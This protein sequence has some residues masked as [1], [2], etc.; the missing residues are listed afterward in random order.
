MLRKSRLLPMPSPDDSWLNSSS[1]EQCMCRRVLRRVNE[2][3]GKI[4][5]I[6]DEATKPMQAIKKGIGHD[7]QNEQG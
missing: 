3:P 1:I 5:D 7:K 2:L 6:M 4:A